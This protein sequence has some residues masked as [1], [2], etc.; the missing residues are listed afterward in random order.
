MCILYTILTYR[1]NNL[2]MA[3]SNKGHVIW[4]M[5][6]SGAGKTTLAIELGRKLKSKGLP[7]VILDGDQLRAGINKDL[8]FDDG[9]RS[10]NIRRTAEM[11]KMLSD[12][13]IITICSLITPKETDRLIIKNILG[14]RLTTAFINCPI[15]LCETRDVKGLYK[16]AR[17]GEI[18][19][20]TGIDSVFEV[21]V[22]ADI[23]IPTDRQTIQES[24]EILFENF[25]SLITKSSAIARG[26]PTTLQHT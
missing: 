11:A 3:I 23:I 13:H 16:K 1:I 6:L 7:S 21:P 9:S 20:F 14:E 4:L 17:S 10:E 2:Q 25:C 8:G 15:E 19:K 22:N 24:V 5:G 18:K 12:N 26:H